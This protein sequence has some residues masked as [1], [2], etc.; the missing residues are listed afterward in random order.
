MV[1][2]APSAAGDFTLFD[3]DGQGNVDG[4]LVDTAMGSGVEIATLSGTAGAL[5]AF[6]RGAG[7]IVYNSVAGDLQ[8]TVS[9]GSDD[10]LRSTDTVWRLEAPST[11]VAP[12][13]CALPQKI[14]VTKGYANAIQFP[15]LALSGAG[16]LTATLALPAGLDLAGMPGWVPTVTGS[17]DTSAGAVTVAVADGGRTLALA[18]TAAAVEAYLGAAGHLV[19]NGPGQFNGQPMPV[20]L[21]LAGN[22]QSASLTITLDEPQQPTN[23]DQNIRLRLQPADPAGG[24]WVNLAFPRPG[25]G[26]TLQLIETADVA[27]AQVLFVEF[28][29]PRATLQVAGLADTAYGSVAGGTVTVARGATIAAGASTFEAVRFIGTAADLNTFF[30]VP[31]NVRY[32]AGTGAV[33]VAARVGTYGLAVSGPAPVAGA[34]ISV[35]GVAT[36]PVVYTVTANDL[37]ANGDGFQSRIWQ[38]PHKRAVCDRVRLDA[39]I[40][41]S[42]LLD[43]Q[44]KFATVSTNIHH[45]VRGL[46]C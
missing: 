23:T 33:S 24:A 4:V 10:T 17:V 34:Q 46:E 13:I 28:E 12:Q 40:G 43:P 41:H 16:T 21:T 32:D 39:E 5:N 8:V 1:L 20:T 27:A 29:V 22:G 6:F 9:A 15:G 31:G 44:T 42:K 37:S 18:G 36:G 30:A 2:R 14:W 3:D 35:T 38:I 25:S 19:Y 11:A 45:L 26:N 7:N